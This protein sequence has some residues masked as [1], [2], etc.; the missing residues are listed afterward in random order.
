MMRSKEE[1]S[2]WLRCMGGADFVLG[3]HLRLGYVVSDLDLK[4]SHPNLR[5]S[6]LLPVLVIYE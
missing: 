4:C 1:K 3:Q 6:H 5:V 2:N